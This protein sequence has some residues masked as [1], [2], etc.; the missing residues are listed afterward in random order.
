MTYLWMLLN[1]TRL[2]QISL[3][4]LALNL[5][6]L[7]KASRTHLCTHRILVR[8]L[9]DQLKRLEHILHASRTELRDLLLIPAF[10]LPESQ[11]VIRAE[12]GDTFTGSDGD[13]AA[14]VCGLLLCAAA[15]SF[16][17]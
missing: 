10:R 8:T 17:S 5:I 12:I 2:T 4:S 1:E 9:I 7:P 11:G 15:T 16:G 6:V 3:F 14:A 13:A